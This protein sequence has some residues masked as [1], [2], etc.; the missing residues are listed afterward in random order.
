M[1]A[2]ETLRKTKPEEAAH[3]EAKEK[4][5]TAEEEYSTPLYVHPNLLEGLRRYQD[6]YSFGKAEKFVPDRSESAILWQGFRL[7]HR[8]T[9]AWEAE[10]HDKQMDS[11][12][13]EQEKGAS[14]SPGSSARKV[15]G[16]EE[17]AVPAGSRP[18]MFKGSPRRAR[19]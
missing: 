16:A 11:Q 12:K 15:Y 18:K 5:D 2:A 19:R 10:Q 4:R 1:E 13:A 7:A 8:L 3:L 9:A 6:Y 17:D 14:K